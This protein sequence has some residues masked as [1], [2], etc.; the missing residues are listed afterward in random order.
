[1]EELKFEVKKLQK[2][3]DFL[4]KRI[5]SLELEKLQNVK[6]RDSY[7]EVHHD[8][9]AEMDGISGKS[10]DLQQKVEDLEHQ[11]LILQKSNEMLKN[12]QSTD[13]QDLL[14]RIQ[15]LEESVEDKDLEIKT[16]QEAIKLKEE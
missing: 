13:K 12:G 9:L 5:D 4:Q 16:M 15:V 7:I 2:E 8:D 6:P 10:E 14:S 3:N 11:I 1:M